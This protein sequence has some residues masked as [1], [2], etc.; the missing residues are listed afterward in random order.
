MTLE[1]FALDKN[2]W[3]I[4]LKTAAVGRFQNFSMA[5]EEVCKLSRK[6]KI[7]IQ[8]LEELSPVRG[9]CLTVSG[10]QINFYSDFFPVHVLSSTSNYWSSPWTVKCFSFLCLLHVFPKI[11][12]K[13]DHW[14]IFCLIYF[15]PFFLLSA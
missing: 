14:Y 5:P 7:Q 10:D 12:S 1:H 13:N 3:N 11:Y 4:S 9:T 8:V 2:P 15:T 6:Q